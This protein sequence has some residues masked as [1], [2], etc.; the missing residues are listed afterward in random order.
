MWRKRSAP[1]WESVQIQN[2]YQIRINFYLWGLIDPYHC[3][4][5]GAVA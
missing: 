3:D 5:A 1:A 2:L 4:V